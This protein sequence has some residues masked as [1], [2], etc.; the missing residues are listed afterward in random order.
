MFADALT[1]R[2][3]Q[4][5]VSGRFPLPWFVQKISQIH[6]H[7]YLLS[8]RLGPGERLRWLISLRPG[9]PTWSRWQ[10]AKPQARPPSSFTMLCRKHLQG[11][12]LLALESHYPERCLSLV[13]PHHRLILELLDRHP[14]LVLVDSESRVLGAH[15]MRR[16]GDRLLRIR[17]PYLSPP[18]PPLPEAQTLSAYQ[19][20]EFYLSEPPPEWPQSLLKHCFGLSPEA[21]RCLSTRWDDLQTSWK[22]LWDRCQPGNYRACKS[23]ER[24]S[25]WGN[26]DSGPLSLLE[27]EESSWARSPSLALPGL[28]QERQRALKGLERQRRKLQTRLEK[29]A[30]D[31]TQVTRADLLQREGELLLTYQ[32]QLPKGKEQV[33]LLDFDGERR[34]QIQLD[35][36]LS[37]LEV[38][39]KRL[40]RA[41]KLRRSLP[42]VESRVTQT[43]EELRQLE[44]RRLQLEQAE[45]LAE[46]K[47][48]LK[49]PQDPQVR[50]GVRAS[51]P[52][53][54]LFELPEQPS[55]QILVGR[56]PR[57]NDALIRRLAARNDLW[58]HVK[59]APGAHVVL[60]TA[61]R[62]PE[63]EVIEAAAY[64]AARYSSRA[65][66]SRVLV[67]FTSSQRVRKPAGSPAGFVLYDE[68]LT[69]WVQPGLPPSGLK[70]ADH[71]EGDRKKG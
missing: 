42:I 19:L 16:A 9:D 69:L 71:Q 1:L 46:L 13:F 33:E 34:L 11:R 62:S 65:E 12:P 37:A 68:E 27:V 39:R 35:P 48:W 52:R 36:A 50:P 5:E 64:L 47:A 59:D 24:L 8:C 66:E 26:L 22:A 61:G 44:V 51:G 18:R 45:S 58:F 60:K 2:A 56:S 53:S 4:Q 25:L 17:Q 43:Q 30:Q 31:R 23:G 63:T 41:A 15:Q 20:E 70:R 29:L 21:C 38:A 40:R 28:E 32:H 67:S 49:P 10:G 57:Q 6:D 54:Y 7:D 3:Y 55:Y 14:N